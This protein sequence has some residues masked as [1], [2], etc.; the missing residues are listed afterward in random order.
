MM[1][2]L[3]M[4]AILIGA[5][6]GSRFKVF[7]LV[8]ATVIGSAVTLGAGMAY[9]ESLW[10]VLLAMVLTTAALQIGYLA[11]IVIAGARVSKD[12]PGP[13]AVAQRHVD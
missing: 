1:I 3:T 10:S 13:V 7:V 11:A 9:S 4:I 8:P 5:I 12:L 2:M 6:L